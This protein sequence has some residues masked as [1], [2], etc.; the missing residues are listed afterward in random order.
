MLIINL[1]S[2]A[3]V[4]SCSMWEKSALI[5]VSSLA[6]HP[7]GISQKFLLFNNVKKNSKPNIW[8]AGLQTL[9]GEDSA[10]FPWPDNWFFLLRLREKDLILYITLFK[11]VEK[12]MSLLH[13]NK[14]YR[15]C[16]NLQALENQSLFFLNVLVP[17]QCCHRAHASWQKEQGAIGCQWET[18][19][20]DTAFWCHTASHEWSHDNSKKHVKARSLLWLMV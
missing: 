6:I 4:E 3:F 8:R 11:L 5:F 1:A 15:I 2:L 13:D 10:W 7:Y 20:A 14:G 18:L 16:K 9:S 19:P 12:L 17:L